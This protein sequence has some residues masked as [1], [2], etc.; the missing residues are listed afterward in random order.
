MSI[1]DRRLSVQ[2]AP[3]RRKSSLSAGLTPEDG[4]T[5]QAQTMV[6]SGSEQPALSDRMIQNPL[7]EPLKIV[8]CLYPDGLQV[9][10]DHF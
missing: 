10:T 5:R 4:T 8:E 3:C 7:S 1:L 9:P 2:D 6:R